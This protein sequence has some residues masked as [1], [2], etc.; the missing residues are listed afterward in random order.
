MV[1]VRA[2]LADR[3]KYQ[4]R[5][6]EARRKGLPTAAVG[7]GSMAE[8]QLRQQ[9]QQSRERS[10]ELEQEKQQLQQQLSQQGAAYRQLRQTHQEE[11]Q[12]AN[13]RA[14]R[15]QQQF[16]EQVSQI[17]NTCKEP[18]IVNVS[19]LHVNSSIIGNGSCT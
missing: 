10:R 11:L 9:V 7:D 12:A 18:P 1:V 5:L 19:I 14:E 15:A 16:Q 8:Q 2:A 4:D 3:R 6:A 13:T 17:L